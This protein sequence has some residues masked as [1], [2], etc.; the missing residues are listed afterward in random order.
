MSTAAVSTLIRFKNTMVHLNQF[1]CLVAGPR[2]RAQFAASYVDRMIEVVDSVAR[3][4]GSEI[5]F[6][7]RRLVRGPKRWWRFW[8]VFVA[9]QCSAFGAGFPSLLELESRPHPKSRSESHLKPP[10][11]PI[12]PS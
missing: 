9:L 2:L 6:Q 3:V 5:R 8:L 4:V 1:M 7:E 10:S 11:N 12:P